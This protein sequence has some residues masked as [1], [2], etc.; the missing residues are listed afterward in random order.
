MLGQDLEVRAILNYEMDEGGQN[1]AN[2]NKFVALIKDTATI[3]ASSEKLKMNVG[4][5]SCT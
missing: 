2:V 3:W 4:F 1:R 5:S